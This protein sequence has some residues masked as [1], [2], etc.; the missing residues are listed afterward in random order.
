MPVLVFG[1]YLLVIR[2]RYRVGWLEAGGIA[3]VAWIAV[4]IMLY[5]LAAVGVTSFKP[6]GVPGV[7][8]GKSYS[9]PSSSRTT[10]A[11]FETAPTDER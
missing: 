10:S 4:I 9:D 11:A 7:W 5:V 6:T 1:A 2:F 3:L 8:A